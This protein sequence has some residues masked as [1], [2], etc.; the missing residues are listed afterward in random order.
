MRIGLD[1]VTP[2]KAM[3][4]AEKGDGGV[5][6]YLR[7]LMHE[8]PVQDPTN[9]YTL[10]AARGGFELFAG[11]PPLPNLTHYPCPGLH[12]N[13]VARVAYEQTIYPQ[14][15][16]RSGLNVLL[17]TC[18]TMPLAA[19]M[20]TIIVLHSI[21]YF[22]FTA[23]YSLPRILYL[24]LMVPKALS[25]AV[26][27]ITVSE[28]ARRDVLD[29]VPIAPEKV[30]V[31]H[32]GLHERFRNAYA[33]QNDLAVD[34]TVAKYIDIEQGP[35]IFAIST[36]FRF[37][38]YERTIQAF[39]RIKQ[40]TNLPHRL[41]IFGREFDVTRT[42]LLQVAA[43][44]GLHPGDVLCKPG[45]PNQDVPALLLRASM[46]TYASLYETFGIPLLEAM[47]CGCPVLTSNVTSLPEIAGEA[48][49]IVDP[50]SVESIA[51]GMERILRDAQWRETLIA[52]GLLRAKQF[53]WEK[54]ARETL[55]I[56]Y[57]VAGRAAI[58]S[59]PMPSR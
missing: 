55:N 37:K 53:S 47:A 25:R 36:L 34:E 40:R 18:N 2:G 26:K 56:I 6:I 52:R 19:T 14:I 29:R 48:A 15:L 9:Q 32:H 31:V 42:E 41:V 57:D 30:H 51:Q 1:C 39:A 43:D 20:P 44:A 50:Y 10:F 22:Y 35:Y 59:T 58:P 4:P 5:R 13:Q 16:N 27:I 23:S 28:S 21:Q 49:E 54:S 17:A 11:N 12:T 7:H 8:I 45:V 33:N 38:N 24:R 46:M 3:Q